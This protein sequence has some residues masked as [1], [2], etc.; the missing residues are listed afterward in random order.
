MK[1]SHYLKGKET[2]LD[3]L[4]IAK[5][6]QYRERVEVYGITPTG[7]VLGGYY[8][9]TKNSFGVFGGGVDAGETPAQAAKREFLEEA[10]RNITNLKKVGP[11]FKEPWHTPT[12]PMSEKNKQRRKEFPG[13]SRTTYFIGALGGKGIA[14]DTSDI[15]HN[16]KNLKLHPIDDI[17]RRQHKEI[18]SNPDPNYVKILNRRLKVLNTIK[19]YVENKKTAQE[20][21]PGIPVQKP[22]SRLPKI[23]PDTQNRWTLAVQSHEATRAGKHKDL[24]LVDPDS[25][26]AHSW[27]IPKDRLPEPGERLLAVQTF[28][29]TP[30][31]A[32]HFGEKEPQL[33]QKGYGKGRVRMALKE[34]AD[35]IESDNNKVRFNIY[36]GKNNQ[37]YLLRR[38]KDKSWLIQNV[39]PTKE[40]FP[41]VPNS[42]PK[43]KEVKPDA[44]DITNEKQ[45]MMAKVDGAHNSFI[46]D[47]G[48]PL[49][50]FSHRPTERETGLIEHTHRFLPGLSIKIPKK[51]D[52]LVLRGE[53][54][55]ADPHTGRVRQA[56]E[57]GAV[58]NSNVWKSR[59]IQTHSPLRAVIFDVVRQKNKE[60][61]NIPY[62]E[63]LK[64]LKDVNKK[65]PFLELPPTAVTPKEKI[66]LLNKIRTGQ[67]P[68]TSEG[69]VL[70]NR[71]GGAPIKAKF[72]PDHDV[73]VREIFPEQGSR[74]LAGGFSYSWTPQGKIVGRV[75]T[76][77]SHAIKKDMFENP[78]KYKGRVARVQA[79]DVYTD[80][81]N[82]KKPG[83]LRAP[84]FK[85]WHLD[86]GLQPIEK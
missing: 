19:D 30:E 70:W 71:E 63:K 53:L 29:H 24:R 60:L 54:F 39:T 28:T 26:K 59:E 48:K 76:G 58:L 46:L 49:R 43:Y 12:G 66:D 79:L 75:G 57:T 68:I 17:I 10:Q 1:T 55:A 20:Y 14:E 85:D 23:T 40:K 77:F 82:P 67:E 3:L 22:I 37:E 2:V 9:N 31:Y 78:N 83:A 84:S 4:G 64:I 62:D 11:V 36:Q 15:S 47:A 38:L 5:N 44:I 61:E 56:V 32:L 34:P 6:A 51:L 86:K 16:L 25:G 13:G 65:L 18:E 81:N 41:N 8:K 21:A 69:V 52:G 74:E 7:K 80:P 45:L 73:Y 35:I 50:I 27:A 42:K 33:I 72:R